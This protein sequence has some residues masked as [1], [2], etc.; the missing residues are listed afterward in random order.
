MDQIKIGKYIAKCRKNNKITQSELAEKLGVT[1]RAIS[2]WENGKNL[3]DVSFFK[4]LCNELNITIN[5]LLSGEKVEKNTYQEK[6]EENVFSVISN[7]NTKITRIRKTILILVSMIIVILLTL[8]L[9]ANHKVILNY[10]GNRMYVEE[11]DNHLFCHMF[12]FYQQFYF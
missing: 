3:P 9:V 5:D 1:D 8:I 6:L 12:L 4:P 7:V 10:D 11:K 2:N